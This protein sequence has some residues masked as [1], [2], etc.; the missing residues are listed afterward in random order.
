MAP[1]PFRYGRHSIAL[2]KCR[3]FW[4]GRHSI[5]LSKCRSFWLGRSAYVGVTVESA[6]VG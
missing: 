5:A 3:S 1:L 2:S 4:Y 6:P